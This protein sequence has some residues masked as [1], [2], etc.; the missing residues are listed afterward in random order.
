MDAINDKIFPGSILAKVGLYAVNETAEPWKRESIT[1]GPRPSDRQSRVKINLFRGRNLPPWDPDTG[2]LDAYVKVRMSN[3]QSS[4]GCQSRST[5]APSSNRNS[6]RSPQITLG[7]QTLTSS[8]KPNSRNPSWYES[9]QFSTLL[10]PDKTRRPEV[11]V[12]IWD[13][14]EGL[15][16]TGENRRR[17]W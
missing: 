7:S 15:G 14:D 1:L 5:L 16:E 10:P 4:D 11:V 3:Y 9:L 6:L 2:A 17:E 12:Q 13:R 8:V